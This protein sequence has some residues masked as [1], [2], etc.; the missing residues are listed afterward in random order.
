MY[1][2]FKTDTGSLRTISYMNFLSAYQYN[3]FNDKD[4]IG[5][6]KLKNI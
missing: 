6:I 4:L 5:V 1:V 2:R 3:L